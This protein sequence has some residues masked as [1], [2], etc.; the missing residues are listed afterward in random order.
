MDDKQR[1]ILRRKGELQAKLQ[2]PQQGMMNQQMSPGMANQGM[3]GFPQG[4]MRPPGQGQM[5]PGMPGQDQM[6]QRMQGQGQMRPGMQGQ[7]DQM[8][9]H[10]PGQGQ[11]RPGMH[12]QDQMGQRMPGQGQMRPGMQMQD[13][14]QMGSG[15]QGHDQGQGQ[16]GPGMQGH[17]QGHGQMRP[18]MQ[19]HDQ[20]GQRMPGQGHLRP[21]MNQNR[22][23]GPR[24]P[25][26][27]HM[28]GQRPP[29]DPRGQSA[30][31]GQFR[32]G[33]H[34]HQQQ[35]D[36]SEDSGFN[37]GQGQMEGDD[38]EI[39]DDENGSQEIDMS[40]NLGNFGPRGRGNQ[41][42]RP[43]I[44]GLQSQFSGNT[45][46]SNRD[47]NTPVPN[48]PFRKGNM[49]RNTGGPKPLMSL[50]LDEENTEEEQYPEI[51]YNEEYYENLENW[52]SLGSGPRFGARGGMHEQR[53]RFGMRGGQNQ[54]NRFGFPGNQH[55]NRFPNPNRMPGPGG[56]DEQDSQQNRFPNQ[57]RMPGPGREGEQDGQHNRFEPPGGRQQSWLQ[58]HLQGPSNEP[59]H[60]LPGSRGGNFNNSNKPMPVQ[61]KIGRPPANVFQS[62]YM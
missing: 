23:Q 43:L 44:P 9:Q 15:M 14:G 46:S 60:P 61:S 19:G 33:M 8:G 57:N 21:G 7:G 24:G 17:D 56:R 36:H 37:Q 25:G 50:N 1:D 52:E 39:E 59:T 62:P 11:L 54:G 48:N 26:Q 31:G 45:F 51:E 30:G 20:M 13:Q 42:P 55:G 58:K 49:G 53:P 27:N 40:G 16:M 41:G 18:G 10:M 29:F 3:G 35:R 28:R 12:G 47:L 34:P 32:P 22:M 4:Q 38:M 2:A 6:G 5:R